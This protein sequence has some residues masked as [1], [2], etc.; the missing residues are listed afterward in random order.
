MG[1]VNQKKISLSNS[2]FIIYIL[3]NLT[4]LTPLFYMDIKNQTNSSHI[5]RF[6]HSESIRSRE[7]ICSFSIRARGSTTESIQMG[8]GVESLKIE[9]EF[10]VK[11]GSF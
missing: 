8:V 6:E 7:H 3:Q 11:S 1:S 2:G 10:T 4:L 5:L 9:W